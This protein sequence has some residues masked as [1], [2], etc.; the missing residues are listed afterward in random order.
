V[1]HEL[2]TTSCAILGLLA[3][4]PWTAYELAAEMQHCFGYFW[5]RAD[6]RSYAEADRLVAHG[7]ATAQRDFVGRRP[8]TT[9]AITPAGR[10]ALEA[11]LGSPFKAFTLEFEGLIRVF[12]ARSGTREQLL[13][14][15][16]RVEAEADALLRFAAH[17]AQAYYEC[18]APFQEEEGHLRA[19]VF[20]VM[21][22]F[23]QLM[24]RWAE[25]TRAEVETWDDL[26]PEDK[27]ERA[28][29]IIRS[30]WTQ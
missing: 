29:E 16:D 25:R 15:L 14:T 28:I 24:Q 4:R 27:R 9:Y 8:R 3:L 17:A 13:H 21:V 30:A 23:A 20:T 6:S 26:S 10:A 19:F 5:P 22:P 11:W 12:L 7:L 1:K 2:N 18:K